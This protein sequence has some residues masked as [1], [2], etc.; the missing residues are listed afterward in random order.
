MKDSLNSTVLYNFQKFH[1][2]DN[3]IITSFK[4]VP[5]PYIAPPSSLFLT[6]NH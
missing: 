5:Y 1:I 6:G 4:K 2:H 3:A